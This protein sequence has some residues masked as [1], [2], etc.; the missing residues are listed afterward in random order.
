ML[1]IAAW[2]PSL[3]ASGTGWPATD[4]RVRSNPTLNHRTAAMAI[5][6]IGIRFACA[7]LMLNPSTATV[8]S[9]YADT[10]GRDSLFALNVKTGLE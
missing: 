10:M 9:R 1:R 4:K 3:S 6:R 8:R 7:L 5:H 2:R